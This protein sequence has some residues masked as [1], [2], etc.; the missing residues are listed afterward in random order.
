MWKNWN[1]TKIQGLHELTAELLKKYITN[2]EQVFPDQLNYS[3]WKLTTSKFEVGS[4]RLAKPSDCVDYSIM[5][6]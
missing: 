1:K 2:T 5:Q 3:L 6:R 4:K